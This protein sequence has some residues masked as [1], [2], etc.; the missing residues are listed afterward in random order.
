MSNH[1]VRRRADR[2]AFFITAA[3]AL[4]ALSGCQRSEPVA[5]EKSNKLI[6]PVARME[7]AAAAGAAAPAAAQAGMAAA[8]PAGAAPAGSWAMW[9]FPPKRR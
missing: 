7:M 2:G 1:P 9:P 3:A 5:E 6:Q 8:A 4:L